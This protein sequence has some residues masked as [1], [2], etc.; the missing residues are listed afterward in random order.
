VEEAV[1]I[2]ENHLIVIGIGPSG[3]FTSRIYGKKRREIARHSF[4]N[5]KN[6]PFLSQTNQ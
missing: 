2:E 5:E 3:T 1:V 4:F 6:F